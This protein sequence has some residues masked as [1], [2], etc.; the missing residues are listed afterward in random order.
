[1]NE[2]EDLV[3]KNTEYQMEDSYADH[4]YGLEEELY[5]KRKE[6]GNLLGGGLQ[7]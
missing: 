7:F 6:I 5:N 1:M 3:L 4:G 2:H